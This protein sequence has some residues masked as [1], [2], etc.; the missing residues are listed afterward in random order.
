MAGMQG[1]PLARLAAPSVVAPV[2]L[3]LLACA[4]GCGGSE[5]DNGVT[6]QKD[7]STLFADCTL[8]HN[9]ASPSAGVPPQ[10]P[11]ILDPYEPGNG[12][13]VAPSYWKEGH[14]NLPYPD[15][16]V[17]PGD[18]DQ[19]FLLIKLSD[20][21]LGLLSDAGAYMPY[22][23]PPITAEELAKIE[24]WVSSG[25]QDDDF[26]RSQ[27]YG[28][29]VGP[30][31]FQPAKCDLCHYKGTP[32]PPDMTDPFGPEGVVGIP[33][34]FRSDLLRVAPGDPD[35]SLLVQR[36]RESAGD[37]LPSSEFGAPMP[38]PVTPLDDA[39]QALVKEWIL[40]GARP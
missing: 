27:V 6:Y 33:S 5:A 40:E 9:P 4:P 34:I 3:V 31:V 21:S 38:K 7:I 25:A 1:V 17:T 28:I 18:P 14:K 10:G 32:H 19:S 23:V 30:V 22:A 20:P 2:L 39:Q 24:Q 36:V 8:C 35:A 15:R 29:F 26:F 16:L 11:D 13:T 37:N 12:L